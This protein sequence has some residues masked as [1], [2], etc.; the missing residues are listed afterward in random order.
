[1]TTA[2]F[3]EET[4]AV[5]TQNVAA[6]SL[7]SDVQSG[8][9]AEKHIYKL[10]AEGILLGDAGKFRPGDNVTQ[11]E[12]ITIAIRFMN[13]DSQRGNDAGATDDLKV[14]NY[15]KP[16]LDLALSKNLINKNEEIAAT[17]D[18]EA[19]GEK[20]ASREWVAKLL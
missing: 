11:Q 9:W 12:A 2:A 19:W 18:G 4:P 17:K 7:F 5:T 14:G 15:F 1:G 13:L 10:A 6:V 8:F 3:A 16:Y 20:K